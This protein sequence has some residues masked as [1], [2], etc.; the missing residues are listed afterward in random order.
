M[1]HRSYKAKY[2]LKFV[3]E[4]Y[5]KGLIK[6]SFTKKLN[7]SFLER[8]YIVLYTIKYSYNKIYIYVCMRACVCVRVYY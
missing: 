8:R 2:F 3:I 6:L 5:G 7:Q 4:K 1:V